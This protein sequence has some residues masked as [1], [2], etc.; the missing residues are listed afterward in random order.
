MD[1]K[2]K[3]SENDVLKEL[4][5]KKTLVTIYLM[6]GYQFEG[7]ITGFDEKMITVLSGERKMHIYKHAISTFA[8]GYGTPGNGTRPQ[9]APYRTNRPGPLYR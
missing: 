6:R 8:E 3:Y 9:G 1:E 2:Q 5:E 7:I 4:M